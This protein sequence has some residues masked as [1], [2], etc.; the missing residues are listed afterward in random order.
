MD[1]G[2]RDAEHEADALYDTRESLSKDVEISSPSP[3]TY[4]ISA[5]GV[6]SGK[7][8]KISCK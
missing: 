5:L 1:L 3:E 4:G 6:A 2:D 7:G 8:G